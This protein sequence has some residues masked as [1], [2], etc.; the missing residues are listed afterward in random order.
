MLGLVARQ[1]DEWNMWGLADAISERSRVLDAKCDEIG[2]DP[3]TILRST[4]ALVMVSDDHRAAAE[5]VQRVSPRAA[6]AGSVE[7]FAEEVQRWAAAGITEVIVPDMA[8]GRG[9]QRLENLDA[10]RAAVL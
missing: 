10:L 6:I 1:A 3:E 9:S 4:Q 8:L 7:R 5:F 2:R